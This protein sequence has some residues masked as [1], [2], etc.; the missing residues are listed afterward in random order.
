MKGGVTWEEAWGLSYTDRE[1][2]IES[3]NEK[4]RKESGDTT[5]YM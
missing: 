1:L 5:E 2:M 3:L 4:I